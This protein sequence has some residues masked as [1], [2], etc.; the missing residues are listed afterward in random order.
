MVRTYRQAGVDVAEAERAV[1]RIARA[2]AATATPA[3]LG[4]VGGFAGLFRFDP[5]VHPD[6]VLVSSTDGVGTKLKVALGLGRH[7]TIGVDLVHCCLNDILVTGAEPLFFLD[8]LALGDL[9][10]DVVAEIVGGVAAGCVAAGIP[11]IGG[12]TAQMPDVYDGDD[13]D[14]AGFIVGV[15][16]RAGLIDGS[17]V[18]PGD[19]LL[20]LPSSGLHTNGY[21]LAR[22]VL[23][24]TVWREPMP[25]GG[26][27][28]GDALL[29]PHRSYLDEVRALR[30][31]A[32]VRA[33]AHITGGGWEGNVPR[34]LPDGLGVEVHTGSWPVPPIFNLIQ[35]RG[36]IEDTE[37]VRTF[38][39]GVGLTVVVAADQADAALDAVPEA[40]RIGL[41]VEA[42][43]SAPRVR[44]T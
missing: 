20:G 19:A 3:V 17:R 1:E 8:Y 16:S 30:R 12:E 37:M 11:L 18:R 44:F 7:D 6:P 42:D 43:G 24:E 33:M 36:D 39:V 15:V 23:P 40:R 34:T 25:H 2:A 4:G 13:Y 22:R 21:T 38:N 10:A 27:T 31:V 29:Q 35:S 26:G 5:S 14:L 32:D 28:I 41:V 9:R